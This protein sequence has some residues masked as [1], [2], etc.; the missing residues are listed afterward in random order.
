MRECR[1]RDAVRVMWCGA[2]RSEVR[3]GLHQVPGSGAA[4]CLTRMMDCRKPSGAFKD[5]VKSSVVAA[6][7]RLVQTCTKDGYTRIDVQCGCADCYC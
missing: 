2:M 3:P 1:V 5:N 4:Y 6:G 7:Q